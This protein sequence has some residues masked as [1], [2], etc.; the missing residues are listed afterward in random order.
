[1]AS[2]EQRIASKKTGFL[3]TPLESSSISACRQTGMLGMVEIERI[4]ACGRQEFLIEGRLKV[5]PFLTGF[6]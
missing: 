4:P 5:L 3:F 2:S 6:I 1:M